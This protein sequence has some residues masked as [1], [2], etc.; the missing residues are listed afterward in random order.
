M[1]DGH[2]CESC[3]KTFTRKSDL[4]RHTEQVHEGKK[5]EG[6]GSG[7]VYDH[8]IRLDIALNSF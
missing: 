8:F 7:W 2:N 5:S 1:M 6:V 3:S 4:K